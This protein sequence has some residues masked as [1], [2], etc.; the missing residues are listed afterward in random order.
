[1]Q[2]NK[3]RDEDFFKFK[4]EQREIDQQHEMKMLLNFQGNAY[5]TVSTP[6]LH[7]PVNAQIHSPPYSQ[8]Y[9]PPN[10]H[11][12]SPPTN[13]QMYSPPN[14]QQEPRRVDSRLSS[15]QQ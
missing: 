1:M 5:G 12:Y 14:S 3:K 8:I 6:T 10:A 4:T 9:S 13:Q 7:S 2:A 11:F 15:S